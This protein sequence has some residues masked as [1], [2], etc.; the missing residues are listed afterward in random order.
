MS[1]IRYQ[2]SDIRFQGAGFKRA[3]VT[4][5]EPRRKKPPFQTVYISHLQC[6]YFGWAEA[7]KPLWQGLSGA[8]QRLP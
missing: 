1:E 7:S 3:L 8:Q 5:A 2:K 4:H 6:H